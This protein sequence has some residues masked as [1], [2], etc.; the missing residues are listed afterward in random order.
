M[1][2]AHIYKLF[3]VSLRFLLSNSHSCLNALV[4]LIQAHIFKNLA[5]QEKPFPLAC[6]I[7]IFT[8]F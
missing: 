7:E 3:I 4:C 2:E 6:S 1:L 5:D 8:V